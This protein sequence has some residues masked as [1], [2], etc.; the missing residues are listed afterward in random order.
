MKHILAFLLG[1]AVLGRVALA[2]VP[3]AGPCVH[4][5]PIDRVSLGPKSTYRYRYWLAVGTETFSPPPRKGEGARRRA[6]TAG[7]NPTSLPCHASA[8]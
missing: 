5:A 2:A 1:S 6:V 8:S 7:S 4:I 3:A